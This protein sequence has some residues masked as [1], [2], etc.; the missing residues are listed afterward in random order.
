[1]YSNQFQF[2]LERFGESEEKIQFSVNLVGD[3]VIEN[4]SRLNSDASKCFAQTLKHSNAG[5]YSC[6]LSYVWDGRFPIR[7]RPAE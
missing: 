5:R 2:C 6:D 1:L 3:F 4:E 7:N